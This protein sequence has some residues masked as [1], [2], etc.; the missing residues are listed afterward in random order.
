MRD[1]VNDYFRRFYP[2]DWDTNCEPEG[3][4]NGWERRYQGK[5]ADTIFP[6]MCLADGLEISVQGHFGA[7]SYPRGDFEEA[8]RQV[9]ILGPPGIPE[10]G[11]YERACNAVGERMIYPF[12]PVEIV[13]EMITARGGLIET[14]KVDAE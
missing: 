10:L 9:E 3:C 14:S 5:S 8:Y 11:A 4:G 1:A 6:L 7:Y 12:V 2:A 13:S